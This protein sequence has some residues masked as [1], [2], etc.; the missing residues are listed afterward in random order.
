[1]SKTL[2]HQCYVTFY[3]AILDFS[4]IAR[5]MMFYPGSTMAENRVKVK[6]AGRTPSQSGGANGPV[7]VT[8]IAARCR[9]AEPRF[10]GVTLPNR[11]RGVFVI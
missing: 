9:P 2:K 8:Q 4:L 6:A 1:M 5:G 10:E 7:R 3:R 11:M